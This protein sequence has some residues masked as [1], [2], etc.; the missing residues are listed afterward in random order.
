V[1]AELSCPIS[2]EGGFFADFQERIVL[3]GPDDGDGI[4]RRSPDDGPEFEIPVS[5]K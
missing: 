1:R 4:R 3:V 5:R 2:V